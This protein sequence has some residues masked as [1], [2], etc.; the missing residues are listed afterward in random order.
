MVKQVTFIFL[1]LLFSIFANA[2]KE[3][4]AKIDS[5]ETRLKN[6]S[7][8]CN[9]T[10]LADSTKVILL[11]DLA[12][13][14][15][16]NKTDT[17]LILCNEADKLSGKFNYGL[18]IAQSYHVKANLYNGQSDYSNAIKYFS[19]EISVLEK[20]LADDKQSRILLS[21]KAAALN[22]WGNVYKNKGDLPM[23]L[24]LFL[25]ALAVNEE[26]NN[27]E[28]IAINNK[29]IGDIYSSWGK[30]P[31]ALDFF[32]KALGIA[33]KL[34]KDKISA[35]T[36]GSIGLIYRQQN[37]FEKAKEYYQRAL[38]LNQK[39]DDKRGV[40]I[41]YGNLG[42]LYLSKGSTAEAIDCFKMSLKEYEEVGYKKGIASV[43]INMGAI[44]NG[45]GEALEKQR[46]SSLAYK[47]YSE[48]LD[49]YFKG[50][51]IVIEIEDKNTEAINLA[52][53]GLV[54]LNMKKYQESETY[55]LKGLQ[56]SKSIDD[57]E[58]VMEV[59][60]S[61][62]RLYSET[63][64]YR[65][66][67]EHYQLAVAAKDSIFN[68]DK[69]EE[70]TRKE[71]NF[72]QEKKDAIAKVEQEKKDALSEQELE[73]QKLLRNSIAAGAGI[74]ALSS[75]LSFFFYKRKRDA[76]QKQKE[77]SL[78][79]QV[80]ETEMK[81]LRSQMNP[82]FIFNALQSIQTFL[83]KNKSEDANIYLLKFS[84]LMRA[85]LENSRHSEVS[86][87]DDMQALELYMQLE[88]IRLPHPFT[89]QFH[90]D[91]SIDVE[92]A[93]IPPLILQPFVENAIWHGLQY[94]PEPGH[95][96][97]FISKKD[98]ALYATVEDNGIGRDMSKNKAHPMLLKKESLG[99]KLTEE[100]LK[101]LNEIKKIKAQFKI[102]DLF[103][104][105]NK[106]IG[107]R[108]ELSLPL[109]S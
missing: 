73:K 76:E 69:T 22:S 90:I 52:N 5:I 103:T 7:P 88:S 43:Y 61:L 53:I 83:L 16:F 96:D 30:F 25:K 59:N 99:M 47:K 92:E 86:L 6:Y 84:K 20:L 8:I 100:R 10:C 81:A 3:G 102:T 72:E 98:N 1:L 37:N 56:L 66:A 31:E 21:R 94:K 40:G 58:G 41:N 71:M 12:W 55:L 63:N 109:D 97:V 87:K 82:H 50:M 23:A 29:N 104:K 75:L 48:A 35:A 67:W 44:C 15:I 74:I 38:T 26:F 54:Y 45:N 19:Y 13:E 93:T 64:K 106:P 51:K 4:K 39:L 34:H 95:I 77:T 78:S 18:G 107:T 24:D 57:L 62:S 33:E 80:S 85:V 68:A 9:N 105:E 65:M 91:E 108:V 70:I 17:V 36:L 60:Q 2:Q 14:Y 101:I 28:A 49:Y 89:Y 27:L 46:N 11:L 79:L 42:S 32:F